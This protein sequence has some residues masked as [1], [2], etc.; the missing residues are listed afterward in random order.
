VRRSSGLYV[1]DDIAERFR[2]QRETAFDN[3]AALYRE[4][5]GDGR[6]SRLDLIRLSLPLRPRERA[7]GNLGLSF[8]ELIYANRTSF[9]AKNTFTTEV[10]VNDTAAE[11]QALLPPWY[12]LPGQAPK[13][14]AV[15]IVA[16]GI[17]SI[18][19]GSP[20]W[21]FTTRL[22]SAGSITAV[23]AL[24]SAAT[25]SGASALTNKIWEFEGDVIV[26]TLGTTGATAT[27]NG[28]GLL[29]CPAIFLTPFVAEL[30]G[31]AAQPGT[32]STLDP[33]ITNFVNF[34]VAC[35]TSSVSNA[36]QV[37]QLLVYGLN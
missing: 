2:A 17:L 19:T 31:G 13:P 34:N 8:S 21:T 25:T 10:Q 6:L 4:V 26:R 11:A 3:G 37:L 16:R 24:G 28:A 23:I 32:F 15:R 35:G 18:T 27:G 14:Q 5:R 29:A 20:T 7:R 22:G 30:W 9:T 12:F 1:P 33:S 36:V